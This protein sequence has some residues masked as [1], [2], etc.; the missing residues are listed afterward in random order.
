MLLFYRT[1]GIK[2]REYGSFL[3]CILKYGYELLNKFTYY[4]ECNKQEK[5]YIDT[6]GLLTSNNETVAR[7]HK[8]ITHFFYYNY[9]N[10]VFFRSYCQP[11]H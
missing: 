9:L 7:N 4:Y 11:Y 6:K 5:L 8:I 10:S 2:Q 3:I 1:Y